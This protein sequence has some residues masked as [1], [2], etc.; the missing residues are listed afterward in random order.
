[1]NWEDVLRQ[2]K[3]IAVVGGPVTGKSMLTDEVTDRPVIHSDEIPHE[4]ISWSEHSHRVKEKA[5]KE[6]S[7]VV[8]GVAADRAVRKGLQVDAI[9]HCTEPRTKYK[10]GQRILKQQIDRRVHELGGTQYAFTGRDG[11]TVIPRPRK[12]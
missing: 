2:H 11:M 12:G 6:E 3:R 4:N 10:S 7:F 1:M 9:V 5:E 8:A